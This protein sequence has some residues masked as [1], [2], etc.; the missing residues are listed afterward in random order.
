MYKLTIVVAV[1]LGLNGVYGAEVDE[2]ILVEQKRPSLHPIHL[3]NYEEL[4][5]M[6][7]Q[8][9]KKSIAIKRGAFGR[10][11]NSFYGDDY[12][13]TLLSNTYGTDNEISPSEQKRVLAGFWSKM[14]KAHQ[15]NSPI[16]EKQREKRS[17]DFVLTCNSEVECARLKRIVMEQTRSPPGWRTFNKYSWA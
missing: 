10:L 14:V 16:Q 11:P 17:A 7:M 15:K 6:T 9:G 13:K 2:E 5:R 1:L 4:Q 12:F 3:A 8:A